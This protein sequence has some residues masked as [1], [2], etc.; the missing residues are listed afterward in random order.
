MATAGTATID[1]GNAPAKQTEASI[2][3]TGQTSILASS[4]VEAWIMPTAV[5]D[6]NGHSEDEHRIESIKLTVPV[7]TI[8][9]GTGFTI[10][11]ECLVGTTNGKFLVQWVWN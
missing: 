2:A 4:K 10:W 1:F 8:V 3:V 5:A 9:A 7:S 6:P 11:G